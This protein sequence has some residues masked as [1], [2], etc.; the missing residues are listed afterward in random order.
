MFIFAYLRA[1]TDQ[2]DASRA[3]RILEEFAENHGQRIAGWFVENISGARED[4][5]ELLRL[6]E[7]SK[8]GDVMLVE[9][10]DRLTRMN[11][12]AWERLKSVIKSHGLY[13]VSL[14]LPTSWQALDNNLNNQSFHP[15]LLGVINELMLDIL[16]LTARK[17][18]ED[19]KRRQAE[20]I[21]LNKN[22]F[23]GRKADHKR[24]QAVIELR[25]L[26]KSITETMNLTGYSRA[27]VCRIW[28]LHNASESSIS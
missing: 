9:Q 13:I 10:V 27:Q 5:P 22:K 21:A 8:P 15:Q 17:D 6:I 1:S 19:R 23:T 11:F 24:H 14:D 12:S 16:A 7:H 20:G 26:G 25:Q 2:Q 3:K 4:R 28:K 18:Y